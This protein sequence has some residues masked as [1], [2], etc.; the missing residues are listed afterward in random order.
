MNWDQVRN[1]IVPARTMNYNRG[2]KP[3]QII[4]L[5]NAMRQPYKFSAPKTENDIIQGRNNAQGA[6][7]WPK[8]TT[9][10]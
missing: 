10:H 5:T 9:F 4:A 1:S 6:S 7:T 2:N 3:A 8:G